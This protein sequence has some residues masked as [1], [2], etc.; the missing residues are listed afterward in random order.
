[1]RRCILRALQG[2]VSEMTQEQITDTNCIICED[3]RDQLDDMNDQFVDHRR[4]YG[5]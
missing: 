1:M 4:T 5:V 3:C 2:G